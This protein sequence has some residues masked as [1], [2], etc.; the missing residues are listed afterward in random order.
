MARDIRYRVLNNAIEQIFE[1]NYFTGFTFDNISTFVKENTATRVIDDDSDNKST[2]SNVA[3]AIWGEYRANQRTAFLLHDSVQYLVDLVTVRLWSIIEATVYDFAIY[4]LSK[5]E[6]VSDCEKLRT[7]KANALEFLQ[8]SEMER[9]EFLFDEL[10]RSLRLHDD[11]KTGV[12]RF[13]AVLRAL[14][15]GGELDN[16]VSKLIIECCEVRNLIVHKQGRIDKQFVG[17]CPW[18]DAQI[19]ETYRVPLGQALLYGVA[20][21]YYLMEITLRTSKRASEL[22]LDTGLKPTEIAAVQE[23]MRLAKNGI[24]AG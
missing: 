1:V 6:L 15:L 22:H 17:K 20:I 16:N 8:A 13:E 5:P 12:G 2:S 14:N 9:G 19:G 23:A 3:F 4:T 7:L 21:Y 24:D 18:V 11:E 10:I